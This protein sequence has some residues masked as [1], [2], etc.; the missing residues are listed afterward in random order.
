MIK[1]NKLSIKGTYLRITEVT[2]E[3]PTANVTLDGEML[4]AFPLRSVRSGVRA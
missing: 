4:E 1:L 3:K 2:Y